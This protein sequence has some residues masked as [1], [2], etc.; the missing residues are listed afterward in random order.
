MMQLLQLYNV[1]VNAKMIWSKP[2]SL[3]LKQSTSQTRPT[4]GDD[5][6]VYLSFCDGCPRLPN[7]LNGSDHFWTLG[8][9]WH[10]SDILQPN[11]SL[12]YL[13]LLSDKLVYYATYNIVIM[14]HDIQRANSLNLPSFQHD[15]NPTHAN[16]HHATMIYYGTTRNNE[17]HRVA[18]PV[19]HGPCARG[20]RPKQS[21]GPEQLIGQAWASQLLSSHPVQRR[22]DRIIDI[23]RYNREYT[24]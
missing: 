24:Q 12:S 9:Y 1:T 22:P 17:L 6:D 23:N 3:R 5:K 11:L 16:E 7:I 4:A 10:C 13:E 15:W 18:I 19:G 8:H 14:S 2:N 21:R 20:H